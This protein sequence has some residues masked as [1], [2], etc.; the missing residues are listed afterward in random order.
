MQIKRLIAVILCFVLLQPVIKAGAAD[1]SAPSIESKRAI[2]VNL[3]TNI[4]LFEEGARERTAPGN[5]N[6]IV[7]ALIVLNNVPDL[8]TMVTIN[9]S[10][11]DGV[12]NDKNALT[13][14]LKPGEQI[15]VS[16][17]LYCM[18]TRNA[19]DAANALAEHVAGSVK[20][21]V[22]MMNDY[23]K[24]LNCKDTNFTNP[25]GIDDTN[26]YTTAYDM[27]LITKAAYTAPKFMDYANIQY[28]RISATNI[29]DDRNYYSTNNLIVSSP[30][31]FVSDYYY[32]YARGIIASYTPES[33]Y[34]VATAVKA[35][36]LNYICI[37]MG[38]TRNS[39]NKRKSCF[40]D[41]KA[42]SSWVFDN[43]KSVQVLKAK[44]PVTE[45]PVSLSSLADSVVLISPDGY[46]TLLPN[47]VDE[48]SLQRKIEMKEH[49]VK[50][51]IK[52]GDELGEVEF[53][54]NGVEYGRAP[55]VSQSNVSRS[56]ILFIMHEIMAFLTS[57]ALRILIVA[58]ILLFI[59]YIIIT[60]LNKRKRSQ[61]R[62]GGR[63]Y[64]RYR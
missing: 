39:E 20:D 53:I 11:Q 61:R 2:I 55:L 21:F 7:T 4:V 19:C 63:R 54:Y 18:F 47:S 57:I 52:K 62:Y 42:L 34:S 13:A 58:A 38:G 9:S 35:N 22:P 64:K 17:L 59:G 33:G 36:N 15:S 56:T 41:A 26:Q 23:V 45:V 24:K 28:K 14:S 27:F 16:N 12:A 37:V 60:Y 51:P 40:I 8:D 3:E 10:V 31:R 44:E 32:K 30:D 43:Y 6:M 46:T 49:P 25:S 29:T 1:T 5:L 50:A 48:N